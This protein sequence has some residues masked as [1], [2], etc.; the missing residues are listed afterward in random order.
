MFRCNEFVVVIG[1]FFVVNLFLAVIVEEFDD[2]E[3]QESKEAEADVL[4]RERAEEAASA[5]ERWLRKTL[6]N[7]GLLW[8][9]YPS[10]E[11][12]GGWRKGLERAVTS[13]WAACCGLGFTG[14]ALQ[15]VSEER[16]RAQIAIT[17]LPACATARSRA[18]G[19]R[20]AWTRP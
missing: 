8:A 11:G 19:A 2:A 14:V 6:T 13:E 20:L 17:V 12:S 7:A 4:A 15:R 3:T 1:G 5:R 9:C 16:V 10:A 18:A